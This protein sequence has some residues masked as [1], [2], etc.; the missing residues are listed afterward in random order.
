M[1]STPRL[2]RGIRTAQRF[3]APGALLRFHLISSDERL[4]LRPF[5]F[6]YFKQQFGALHQNAH[7]AF[8]DFHCPGIFRGDN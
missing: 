6:F 1:G 2:I 7:L 3:P 5:Y 4:Q 8:E